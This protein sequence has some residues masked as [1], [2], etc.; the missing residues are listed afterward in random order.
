[1]TT[2]N[3]SEAAAG[4][5]WAIIS[6]A[7]P[8]ADIRVWSYSLKL[9]RLQLAFLGTK[10]GLEPMNWDAISAIAEILG[11]IAVVVTLMYL[12]I[13]IRQSTKVARSATRQAIAESAERLGA[14]LL[15][16]SGMAEIFVKHFNGEELSAVENLRLQARCYRDMRHWENIHYQVSE[17]LVTNDQWSGFRKNLVALF[18][19]PIYREYWENESEHYSEKFGAEVAS[20]IVESQKNEMN[21]TIADRFSK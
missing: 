17:G 6:A 14:D 15:E 13:Q 16:N 2:A 8:T 18:T 5:S 12:A 1:L 9:L 19:L 10:V 3:R 11:A 7:E 20:I 4:D 21:A